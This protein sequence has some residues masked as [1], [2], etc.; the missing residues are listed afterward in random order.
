MASF[1]TNM[2]GNFYN[3]YRKRI[4]RYRLFEYILKNSNRMYIL[5][6]GI[7]YVFVKN[8]LPMHIFLNTLKDIKEIHVYR[9]RASSIL[10][11]DTNI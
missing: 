6:Y 2:A 8:K 4:L 11:S 10:F 5:T 3:E 1:V 7:Y 9:L